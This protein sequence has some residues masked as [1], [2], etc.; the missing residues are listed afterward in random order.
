MNMQLIVEQKHSYDNDDNDDNN[1][2]C[3]KFYLRIYTEV[4]EKLLY[5]VKAH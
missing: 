2:I 1:S 5:I 4:D 3:L